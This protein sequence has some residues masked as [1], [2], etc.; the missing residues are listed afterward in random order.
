M[1]WNLLCMHKIVLTLTDVNMGL[2]KSFK[3]SLKDY[4]SEKAG[5]I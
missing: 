1:D 2:K 5:T 3:A 4:K